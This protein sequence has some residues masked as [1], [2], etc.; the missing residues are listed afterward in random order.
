MKKLLF[1]GLLGSAALFSTGCADA[2]E[3]ATDRL[4]DRQEEC[5]MT[6]P[7]TDDDSTSECTDAGADALEKLADCAE[8]ATCEKVKDSSYLLTCTD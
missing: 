6:V 2:C 3:N 1:A 7:D 4:R 8:A 5:G